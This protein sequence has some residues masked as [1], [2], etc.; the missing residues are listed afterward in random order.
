[1]LPGQQYAADNVTVYGLLMSL[2]GNGPLLP[3]IRPHEPT[4]N[5]RAAWKALKAYYQGDSMN[6]RM[7]KCSL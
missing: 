1:M 2:A 5:G 4:R 7:K 3:F 6:A